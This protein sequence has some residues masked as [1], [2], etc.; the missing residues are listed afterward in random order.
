MPIRSE[1]QELFLMTLDHFR[2]CSRV[3]EIGLDSPA[4]ANFFVGAADR[5]SSVLAERP[6]SP[7]VSVVVARSLGELSSS[8]ASVAAS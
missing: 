8:G 6:Y 3:L 5:S 1:G 2:G 7:T 4:Q